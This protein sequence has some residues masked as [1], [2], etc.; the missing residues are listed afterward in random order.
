MCHVVHLCLESD[1]DA[2]KP[3]GFGN[4]VNGLSNKHARRSIKRESQ[5]KLNILIIFRIVYV[6]KAHDK[7]IDKVGIA[8]HEIHWCRYISDL[9]L[10]MSTFM[11]KVHRFCEV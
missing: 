9:T 5:S 2:L 6:I 1:V 8:D 3:L 4:G 10:R 11:L 7:D